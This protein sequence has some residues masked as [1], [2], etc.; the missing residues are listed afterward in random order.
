[1]SHSCCRG[2]IHAFPVRAIYCCLA[3]VNLKDAQY[4]AHIFTGSIEFTVL[5]LSPPP[6]NKGRFNV[7]SFRRNSKFSIAIE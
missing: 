1:M 3:T 2:L 5:S 6:H 7:K 4:Y